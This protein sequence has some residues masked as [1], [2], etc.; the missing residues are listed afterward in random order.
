MTTTAIPSDGTYVL[1]GS[2]SFISGGGVSNL[3]LVMAR[4]ANT[5]SAS[6]ISAFLV[7]RDMPG[8]SF[9]AQEHKMGWRCQPTCTVNFDA[10]R[11]PE[12][13]LVGDLGQGFKI[14][15]GALDGGRINIGACSVGG[16]RMALDHT[17]EYCSERRQ[18][19][20]SLDAFQ[21]TRHKL[22]D[23]VTRLLMSESMVLQAAAALDARD[24][25]RL[26]DG[27]YATGLSAMAKR[28]ATDECLKVVD[29]CLQL[30]GGY[31]YI[32]EYQIEQR[33][34]DLRVHSILEGTNEIMREVIWKNRTS[35]MQ[36]D[37]GI[38][39]QT[40]T[41]FSSTCWRCVTERFLLGRGFALMTAFFVP[42]FVCDQCTIC[43][44][45]SRALLSALQSGQG[46]HFTRSLGRNLIHDCVIVMSSNV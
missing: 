11:L 1:S 28:V 36:Q 7:E 12:E 6:D 31:G 19:G 43:S 45:Q 33:L 32:H 10:V 40:R 23:C 13:N 18:F 15:M 21:V 44:T 34:R 46:L 27:R 29:D 17:F 30:H 2:K 22:A 42:R 3:Y 26:H 5:G 20:Q 8:V 35:L 9:G 41:R 25:G 39:S 38:Q 4:T 37:Q 16:A 14:A 24:Q